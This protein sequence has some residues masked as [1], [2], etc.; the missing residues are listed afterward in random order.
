LAVGHCHTNAISEFHHH[1]IEI[2]TR[3]T[4]RATFNLMQEL[5]GSATSRT[6]EAL[7]NLFRWG[8][9]KAS[10]FLIVEGTQAL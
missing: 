3:R 8:N 7:K 6:A 10:R 5:D 4:A 2:F 1:R 9:S